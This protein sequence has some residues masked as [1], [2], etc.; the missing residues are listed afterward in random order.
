MIDQPTTI[1]LKR[2]DK[3]VAALMALGAVGLFGW[4]LWFLLPIAIALATNTIY[5]AL[6]LIVLALLVMVFGDRK[7][8]LGISYWWKNQ[9]RKIRRRIVADD[10]IGTLTTVIE[11]FTARQEDIQS[12]IANATAARNRQRADI[13]KCRAKAENED[14]LALAARAAGR[15][16]EFERHAVAGDRWRKNADDMEPLAAQLADMIDRMNQASDLCAAKLDDLQNQ[17]DVL[18]VRLESMKQG[19]TAVR[20]LKGFFGSNPD[21]E[22]LTM[23]VDEVELQASQAEAEIEQFIRVITPQVDAANLQRSAD[24]QSAIARFD[25]YLQAPTTSGAPLLPA[26]TP[27]KVT[28][29]SQKRGA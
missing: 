6:E 14:G 23:S 9:S 8:W 27:E 2:P 29:L 22:M 15:E 21:L 13:K 11:R 16:P 1:T 25:R 4:A 7:T 20:T 3:V 12:H 18:A 17:R 26:A 19:Q 28:T 24:A 5:L 10:P